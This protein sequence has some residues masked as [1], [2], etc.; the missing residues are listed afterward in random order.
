MN[1]KCCCVC[2]SQRKP[3][4]N[5]NHW[6]TNMSNTELELEIFVRM[7]VFKNIDTLY[8]FCYNFKAWNARK[9][10]KLKLQYGSC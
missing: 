2:W 8:G 10:K 9:A 4:L 3:A 7:A 5:Q 1:F 6:H